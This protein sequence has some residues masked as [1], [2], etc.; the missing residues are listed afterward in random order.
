MI[1]AVDLASINF[2]TFNGLVVRGHLEAYDQ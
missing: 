2:G 1:N